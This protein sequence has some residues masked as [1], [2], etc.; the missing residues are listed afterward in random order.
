MTKRLLTAFAVL[1]LALTSVSAQSHTKLERMYTDDDVTDEEWNELSDEEQYNAAHFVIYYTANKK[2]HKD[3]VKDCRIVYKYAQR[4]L[5]AAGKIYG[6][7]SQNYKNL[8]WYCATAASY[9]EINDWAM[10]ESFYRYCK[11]SGEPYRDGEIDDVGIDPLCEYCRRCIK[12]GKFQKAQEILDLITPPIESLLTKDYIPGSVIRDCGEAGVYLIYLNAL[13]DFWSGGNHYPEIMNKAY[14]LGV[15]FLRP[16]TA[17]YRTIDYLKPSRLLPSI[18]NFMKISYDSS[19]P[20]D[21]YDAA[22]FLKGTSDNFNKKMLAE[23]DACGDTSFCEYVD[24]LRNDMDGIPR[25]WSK[26]EDL[27]KPV[28]QIW[29]NRESYFMTK[30]DSLITQEK[31]QKVWDESVVKW[32]QIKNKLSEGETAIEIVNSITLYR[33]REYNAVILN[34]GDSIPTAVRLCND[35]KL[36][37]ILSKGHIYGANSGEIFDAVWR[38]ILPHI[39]GHRLH[40]SPIG[41]L[42]GVNLAAIPDSTGRS[43]GEKFDIHFCTSTGWL[44]ERDTDKAQSNGNSAKWNRIE[45]WGGLQSLPESGAEI[46]AVGKLA[47][48]AGIET[49]IHSGADCTEESFRAISWKKTGII[50]IA[51]HGFRSS[52]PQTGDYDE[53]EDNPLDR[54]GLFLQDGAKN[55]LDGTHSGKKSSEMTFEERKRES[56][57]SNAIDGVLLGSEIARMNMLGTDLVVLS[58]CGSGKG[59]YTDEGVYSIAR[60]FRKA[61]AKTVIA[62]L[63]RIPDGAAKLF[64]TEFYSHLFAGESKTTAFKVATAALKSHPRYSSPAVW[65]QFVMY[66]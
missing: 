13:V 23:V 59:D 32:P 29:E 47:K 22:L 57:K 14:N 31:L 48:A 34:H 46:K 62:T 38:P 51:A 65:T 3:I 17:I 55:P 58:A 26:D 12:S 63:G 5:E 41:L 6:T 39:R 64:M 54:C 20:G 7:K 44:V 16:R 45:L 8:F 42:G 24:S 15:V 49:V 2:N 37:T 36:K 52:R 35:A 53:D 9:D 43:M 27:D 30:A 50:H 25:W 61:G 60:A 40:L 1:L 56:G 33:G 18:T 11:E 19:A 4:A 10:V 66:D 28:F 21:V